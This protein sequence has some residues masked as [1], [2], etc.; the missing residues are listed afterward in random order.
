MMDNLHL[1][2]FVISYVFILIQTLS[3][4][5]YMHVL[6]L[7]VKDVK[8]FKAPEERHILPTCGLLSG[9]KYHLDL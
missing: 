5:S 8:Y 7:I 1:L 9:K 4:W 3:R 2:S 6:A